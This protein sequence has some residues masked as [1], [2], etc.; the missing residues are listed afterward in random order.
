MVG[1]NAGRPARTAPAGLVARLRIVAVTLLVAVL[2][3]AVAALVSLAAVRQTA[4][5]AN[6]TRLSQQADLLIVELQRSAGTAAGR[7]ELLNVLAAQGISVVLIDGAAADSTDRRAQR[8]VQAAGLFAPGATLPVSTSVNLAGAQ[9][10]VEARAL[11]AVEAVVR[12]GRIGGRGGG[13]LP[14]AAATDPARHA[15]SGWRWRSLSRCCWPAWSPL[16][17]AAPPLSPTRWAPA[18]GTCG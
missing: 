12:A 17:C 4:R 8:A 6:A 7:T 5:E 10:L 16:R 13:G 11:P 18:A 3:A 9:F 15:R 14:S 2:V 1:D